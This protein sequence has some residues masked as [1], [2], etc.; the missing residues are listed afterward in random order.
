MADLLI[1][2]VKNIYSIK[3]TVYDWTMECIDVRRSEENDSEDDE[4]YEV[5]V[6]IVPKNGSPSRTKTDIFYVPKVIRGSV[7]VKGKAKQ[8]FF[9]A[10]GNPQIRIGTFY[11]QWGHAYSGTQV[12]D[13]EWRRS[14]RVILTAPYNSETNEKGE[15]MYRFSLINLLKHFN[16]WKPEMI[17]HFNSDLLKSAE[18]TQELDEAQIEG[19]LRDCIIPLGALKKLRFL[20]KNPNLTDSFTIDTAKAFLDIMDNSTIYSRQKTPMDYKFLDTYEALAQELGR[21]DIIRGI[22]RSTTFKIRMSDKFYCKDLQ[23]VINNFMS[24]KRDPDDTL[25]SVEFSNIQSATD[26][27]ALSVAE[28]KSKIY[29]E[30][31]SKGEGGRGHYEKERIDPAYFVGFIDPVFTADGG[32]VNIKNEIS[33]DAIIKDGEA[34]VRLYDRNFN[35]VI[36]PIYD[37]LMSA[38]VSQDNVDYREK[39]LIPINGRYTVYQYGEYKYITDENLIDYIRKEDGILTTSTSMIPFLTKTQSMRGMLGAHMLTQ[40]L[41]VVGSEPDFVYTGEG[42]KLYEETALNA[43][44]PMTGVV[45]AI[46]DDFMKIEDK[47]R[48]S[49][50]VIKKP[51]TYITSDHST[52]S[53]KPAVKVGDKVSEGQTIYECNSFKDKELALGV[54]LYVAFTGYHGLEHEDAVVMSESA[55]AKF[56]H[57]SLEIVKFQVIDQTELVIGKQCVEQIDRLKGRLDD[58]DD[59]GAL[60]PGKSVRSGDV[61][62]VYGFYTKAEEDELTKLAQELDKTA[63]PITYVT[64]K[65][66]SD[67]VSDGVLESVEFIP[68]K[69]IINRPDTFKLASYAAAKN[70]EM[71][72]INSIKLGGANLNEYQIKK[73]QFNDNSILGEL[74]FRIKYLNKLKGTD[75]VSNMF[76]RPSNTAE[77]KFI[78]LLELPKDY[79]TLTK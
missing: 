73:V 7:K 14:D 5:E 70:K 61:L 28:Q 53:F 4:A 47:E 79:S 34:Y 31:W 32:M 68:S 55:A 10:L 30:T 62:F 77:L 29:F 45:T 16:L 2:A 18:L 1:E 19:F 40:A 27:N 50:K 25:K 67:V 24:N 64:V 17:L 66:P 78:D 41:P 51:D 72:N 42:R 46:T 57:E 22:R 49:Y 8:G 20:T 13:V 58:F 36:V 48:G 59:I 12:I 65:C 74:Q 76:G 33:K 56:A 15:V 75:K 39:K 44:S 63:R 60:K 9:T 21:P 37:Y 11:F 54:P 3:Q 6:D 38:T 52:N 71:R 26:T 43:S 35:E 69:S 23:N